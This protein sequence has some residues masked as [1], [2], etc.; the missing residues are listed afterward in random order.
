[1]AQRS[2]RVIDSEPDDD[3]GNVMSPTLSFS[4][5]IIPECITGELPYDG[6][7][8]EN[9]IYYLV[10]VL[11]QTREEWVPASDLQ[12][13]VELINAWHLH[14]AIATAEEKRTYAQLCVEAQQEGEKSHRL[15][16]STCNCV[17]C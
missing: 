8:D 7:D 10:K 12:E 17:D 13:H 5:D 4:E 15:C 1:M 14:K 6:S 2:R 3:L 9:D 16:V 11:G